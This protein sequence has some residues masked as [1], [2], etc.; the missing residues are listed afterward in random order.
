[1]G[2]VSFRFNKL[3]QFWQFTSTN[4]VNARILIRIM[5]L[6]F[7]FVGLAPA[8]QLTHYDPSKAP[9]SP[10]ASDSSRTSEQKPSSGSPEPGQP[11]PPQQ[12]KEPPSPTS[13]QGSS[14]APP[15]PPAETVRISGAAAISS[16]GQVWERQQQ[17]QRAGS[18]PRH[19]GTS[20]PQQPP[21]HPAAPAPTTAAQ[22]L[23][24]RDQTSASSPTASPPRPDYPPPRAPTTPTNNPFANQTSAAQPPLP[25]S[26]LSE[27]IDGRPMR[28][29]PNRPPSGP[30]PVL[31]RSAQ[32]PGQQPPVPGDRREPDRRSPR[33][34]SVDNWRSTNTTG[35]YHLNEISHSCILLAF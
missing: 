13:S 30:A 2:N 9:A 5:S 22:N 27:Q 12:L 19:P 10:T 11:P 3:H 18:P 32:Y 16:P 17:Q 28:A 23:F 33:Q 7:S 8:E 29:D 31:Q 1:M 35:R 34:G 6:S 25:A 14:G 20:Q 26:R 15:P 4:Q 21:P 24:S